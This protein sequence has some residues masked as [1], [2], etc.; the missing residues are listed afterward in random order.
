MRKKQLSMIIL[1]L[2]AFFGVQSIFG[3]KAAADSSIAE[4]VL[5]EIHAQNLGARTDQSQNK[6]RF[7]TYLVNK[8]NGFGYT[9]QQQPFTYTSEDDPPETY[10]GI[11]YIVTKQ[12]ISAEEVVVGAHYDSGFWS[13]DDTKSTEGIDDNGSGVAAVLET[14]AWAQTV[15]L[16]YTITFI[17]FDQE[18][19][20][21]GGSRSYVNQL[22]QSEKKNIAFMVN[23]DSIAG[24]DYCY[25]YGGTDTGNGTVIKAEVV[26]RAKAL[27]ESLGLPIRLN[28]DIPQVRKSPAC[29]DFGDKTPF[30]E[31]GI[32]Y[33][34]M[35]AT[36]WD[37]PGY[38]WN[39]TVKFGTIMHSKYDEFDVLTGPNGFGNRIYSNVATYVSLLKEVLLQANTMNLPV[40]NEPAD[41]PQTGDS[42]PIGLLLVLLIESFLGL[43]IL[44]VCFPRWQEK[45]TA[46]FS[47]SGRYLY[48]I[49]R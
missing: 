27:A 39:Q 6:E 9:V 30:E 4:T 11:N 28:K 5:N 40:E 2:C 3:G 42:S 23:L 41:V 31:A 22:T 43:V 48:T 10:S 24:G 49:G 16:P 13:T 12:G 7:R 18:E 20:G 44:H 21:C 15:S 38:G 45:E 34:Y 25:I 19:T 47:T 17:F 36:N 1:L 37:I 46:K 35:E 32:P 8:L 26:R 33:L 14:A 29:G